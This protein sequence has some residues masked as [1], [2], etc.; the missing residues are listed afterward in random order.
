MP[1]WTGL[2]RHPMFPDE[3]V[4]PFTESNT[5]SAATNTVTLA[6]VP[7]RRI[8]IS[9]IVATSGVAG[10]VTAADLTVTNIVK[11]DGTAGTVTYRYVANTTGAPGLVVDA[12]Q[13]P[14]LAVAE[15]TQV[16]VSLGSIAA[17]TTALE[18]TGFLVG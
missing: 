2:V 8:A 4:T 9:R 15:N 7:G 18:V 6:A 5:A 11:K 10:G 14:L 1:N 12:G 16:V 13:Q 3:N 17:T